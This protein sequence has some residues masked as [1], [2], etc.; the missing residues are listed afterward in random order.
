MCAVAAW[1]CRCQFDFPARR[2]VSIASAPCTGW[3]RQL[4]HICA[5]FRVPARIGLTLIG[6]VV[7]I[8]A[9]QRSRI[10]NDY[11]MSAPSD[12]SRVVMRVM[13]VRSE[14]SE[15]TLIQR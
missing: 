15:P 2:F 6:Y 3:L 11:C 14:W 5:V 7:I 9:R 12:Q 10:A 4:N 1:C 13:R 8:S